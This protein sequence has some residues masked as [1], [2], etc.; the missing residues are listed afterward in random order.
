MTGE[1]LTSGQ[2][3]GLTNVWDEVCVQVQLERS[4]LWYAYEQTVRTLVEHQVNELAP[5][6]RS[7]LWLQTEAGIAWSCSAN[8]EDG[9]P[10]PILDDV[11]PELLSDVWSAAAN[12][13]NPRIRTYLD[14]AASVD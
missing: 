10:L 1:H 6:E 7:A 13:S 4:V 8:G 2:D 14:D 5:F 11:V 9:A 12:W 3:S